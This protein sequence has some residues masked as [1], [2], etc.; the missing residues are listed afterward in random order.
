MAKIGIVLVQGLKIVTGLGPLAQSYAP[1]TGGA[2]VEV[3][4]T[5]EKIIQAVMQAEAMGTAIGVDGSKKL[6]MAAP[7]VE[8]EL[9]LLFKAKGWQIADE[10]AFK[11]AV[12][13][14]ASDT[15]D[16]LNS[17]GDHSVKTTDL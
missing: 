13:K 2:I 1:S 6:L 14:L 12:S 17:V 5:L 16:L 11:A 9:L 3:E 8:Q 10:V 15:A 7:L 4:N